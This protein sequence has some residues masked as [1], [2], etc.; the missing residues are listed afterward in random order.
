MIE[1]HKTELSLNE[2]LDKL[3]YTTDRSD[4]EKII[5]RRG[6]EAHERGAYMDT[7]YW[8]CTRGEIAWYPGVREW[9]HNRG[10]ATDKRKGDQGARP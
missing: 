5:L 3:G 8:L 6:D 9:A 2:L 1:F 10:L 4:P 7:V